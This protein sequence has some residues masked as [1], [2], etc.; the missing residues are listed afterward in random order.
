[1]LGTEHGKN[2]KIMIEQPKVLKP[3]DKII[4]EQIEQIKGTNIKSDTQKKQT[5]IINIINHRGYDCL[6]VMVALNEKTREFTFQKGNKNIGSFTDLQILKYI[7]SQVYPQFLDAISNTSSIDII[8]Q[9]V[10]KVIKINNNI[11]INLLDRHVSP[12]MGKIEM[13]IKLYQWVHDYESN[14]LQD[15]LNKI[16]DQKIVKKIRKVIKQFIYLLLNN[17]LKLSVIISDELKKMQNNDSI[18]MEKQMLRYSVF[19]VHKLNNFVKSEIDEKVIN[20]KLLQ[21]D[22]VKIGTAKL[23]LNNKISQLE[24]SIKEQNNQMKELVKKI[25]ELQQFSPK[26][27]KISGGGKKISSSE[28]TSSSTSEIKS[29][30]TTTSKTS[31][32]TSKSESF[33]SEPSESNKKH[34]EDGC[35][36]TES[37]SNFDISY[38]TSDA[39]NQKSVVDE[40]KKI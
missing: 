15:E 5:Q 20:F 39:N 2:N 30:R 35:Y 3:D 8:E 1:M 9:Y 19:A 13:V 33:Q 22:L 28:K 12:F 37:G 14:G 17:F 11:E 34:S 18:E 10:C 27:D 25:N 38:L 36:F 26:T 32:I 7:C 24:Q 40:I 31:N 29:E 23:T 4:T 16:N 6:S 21:D